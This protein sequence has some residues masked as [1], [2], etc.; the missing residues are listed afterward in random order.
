MSRPLSEHGSDVRDRTLLHNS[1]HN[2][3]I[4]N[5]PYSTRSFVSR[6]LSEHGSDVR[7]RT[8]LHNSSHNNFI[9]KWA[10]Q[11]KIVKRNNMEE[12]EDWSVEEEEVR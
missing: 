4:R 6:P 8:L 5:G 1:S 2:N 3:F 9:R 12:A 10:L 7:D 11:H